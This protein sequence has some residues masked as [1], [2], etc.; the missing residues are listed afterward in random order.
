MQTGA[1]AGAKHVVVHN[2]TVFVNKAVVPQIAGANRLIANR[3]IAPVVFVAT[4]CV[5]NTE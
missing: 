1:V 5:Q 2:L 4:V 3:Q